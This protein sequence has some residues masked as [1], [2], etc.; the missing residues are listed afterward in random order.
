MLVLAALAWGLLWASADR[1][2]AME[3]ADT[4]P[5]LLPPALDSLLR[6]AAWLMMKPAAVA[7]ISRCQP[8]CGS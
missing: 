7:P 6:E 8:S 2:L 4:S 5:G 3:T 1:M